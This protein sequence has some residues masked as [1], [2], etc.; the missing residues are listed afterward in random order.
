MR[1]IIA[2]A[3][4]RH[5]WGKIMDI[6]YNTIL[7]RHRPLSLWVQTVIGTIA[8]M[9]AIFL[10]FTYDTS[11]ADVVFF[12]SD[13]GFWPIASPF[14]L[15]IP[16]A[17]A[18]L[19]WLLAGTLSR[20]ERITAY[21]IALA[22]A[23]ATL[24]FL[25]LLLV[26]S[27]GMGVQGWFLIFVPLAILSAGAVVVSTNWRAGTPRAENAVIAMQVAYLANASFCLIG[28][29]PDWD[30]G[31]CFA[32]VTVSLYVAQMVTLYRQGRDSRLV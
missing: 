32:L 25:G 8:G 18:S 3:N 13:V 27:S 16:I 7:G 28:F 15:A 30:I 5:G 11:P 6:T 14:L 12:G 4:R 26:D 9:G 1:G 17:V 21:G 19:R 31:A 2:T 29:F 23:G 24:F 10:P 20:L 22:L